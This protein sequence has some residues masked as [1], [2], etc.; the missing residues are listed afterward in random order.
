MK[1]FITTI[2]LILSVNGFGQEKIKVND[3]HQKGTLILVDGKYQ[4]HGIWKS[5][6]AKAKYDM[7]KLV[8]IHP[9]GNRR[10]TSEEIQIVQ[11]NNKIKKLENQIVSSNK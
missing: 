6:L 9:K 4:E 2:L 10:W 3:G 8:W 7:G 5:D 1:T 11:L